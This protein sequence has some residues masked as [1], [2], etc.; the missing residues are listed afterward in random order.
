MG[1]LDDIVNPNR[2]NT[3]WDTDYK[4]PRPLQ[5]GDHVL[6]KGI[7]EGDVLELGSKILVSSGMLKTRVK[8]TD[9]RLLPP[10]K[11]APITGQRTLR[12][13]TSRADADVKTELDLRGQTVEEALGNLGLFIDKCVLNNIS[14]V[15]IIHGKGTGALRTAVQEELRHHPNVAEYRLGVYGEGENGVTIAKLK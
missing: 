10:K 1:E 14:E 5:V 3:D 12:R 2:L 7:G 9:L 8:P 13:T 6:I 11:K 15:R 4:L